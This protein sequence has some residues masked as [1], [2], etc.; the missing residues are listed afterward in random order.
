LGDGLQ[1]SRSSKS[2]IFIQRESYNFLTNIKPLQ[3]ALV[4]IGLDLNI[5]TTLSSSTAPVTNQEFQQKTGAA[6]NLLTHLLRSMA[7]F[8]LISEVEKDVFT[9]NRTTRVF[10]NPHVI[11]AAPHISQLHLP[12]SQ[13]LPG[14]LKEHRYQ[15]MTDSKDLPFHKALKTDLT[16][17]E[18]MKQDGEQMKALGHVMVLDSV[19]S[20]V[21]SYPVEDV[22]GSFKPAKDSALLVDIGGGFGQHSV[23]FKNKYPH[24]SGRIIVQDV[25]STLAH[26]PKVDGI[27]F[28]SHD[29]F[30]PQP[31]HSAKFYYLRHIM[32][33]WTDEDCLHI[34]TS[35]IPAMGSESYILIDEVVLPETN[36]P[37]HVAMM[38]IAMMA[39][40]G[41]TERSR[42]DWESLLGRA[43]LKLV[44]V[45]CYDD[46][47]FH[48]VIAAVP[49]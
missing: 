37:W 2:P 27:E 26:A 9:A 13:A 33:D 32:H 22:V 46:V 1:F 42:E 44:D 8:G 16:P 49:K 14:Y 25:P 45:H 30:T 7:S 24:L 21:S 17:F 15:D 43:G 6:P 28:E 31:I 38:N 34:L 47:R 4:D 35:I 36:V 23:A 41:G 18:W 48:S 19:D 11:G 39:S 40:L 5:F 12:V 10:A 29:F 3:W 20:W